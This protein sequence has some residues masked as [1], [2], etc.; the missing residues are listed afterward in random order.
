[1]KPDWEILEHETVYR[2]YFRID[3]Y[4]L[5]HTLFEGGWSR[6]AVKE[7]F[8]SLEKKLVRDRILA[9]EPRIDGRDTRGVRP[10][11]VETGILPRTHGSSLFTRGETQ[12]VVV[13][14]LGTG[15]DAQMIDA[16]EG[17]YREQFMLHYNFPPYCVGETGFMGGPKRREIGHGKLAKRGI[18][19]VMPSQDDFPYVIRV[20]SEITESNG[21]SSM[22]SVCGTSLSLMDAGVPIKAPVAGIAM[23]LIKEGD[24]FAVLSDILGDED[25]LGDMDFKVA[26][27]SE[28]VTALQMDIKID[29]ITREIMGQ[30]LEQAREGRLHILEVMNAEIGEPRGDLSE[31]APRFITVKID[32]EKIAS[33]IGKGGSVIRSMTE[34][35]GATIDIEDD[36]TIKIASADK[37]AAEKQLY[38]FVVANPSSYHFYEAAEVLGDLASAQ[39]NWTK[40]A[41]YYGSLAGS[42]WP[43][44]KLK[45]DV[46]VAQT[47]VNQGNYPEAAKKYDAILASSLNDPEAR[48]MKLLAQV[49]KAKCLAEGSEP[50]Q[51]VTM[52]EDIIAKNDPQDAELFARAYNALGDAH[53]KLNQP[54]DALLAYLHT[55]VLFFSH[56]DAHAEALY[57]LVNLWTDQN[58]NDRALESRN[59][60]RTRYSNS[61]WANQN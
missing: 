52:I 38:D 21:S 48:R 19:G 57:R 40:A 20:V 54:E 36:G 4:R 39:G 6:D 32:P 2:G 60:L 14:T 25:H 16:L 58:Q 27:S 46:L 44:Y 55:H 51:A 50:Q 18:Q 12:A 59:L 26:G 9:G 45:S 31:Y 13:T 33:V 11:D 37:A 61:R 24:R 42:G 47:L 43:E 34:E 17:G 30:A 7:A 22:A 1:M 35:T 23:G 15:R 10:I 56:S 41:S 29:G 5:R 28:G 53:R 3:R 49:G 8:G